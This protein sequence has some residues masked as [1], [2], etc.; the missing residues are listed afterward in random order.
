MTKTPSPPG[1][2]N[3]AGWWWWC[4]W[5][6]SRGSRCWLFRGWGWDGRM[7]RPRAGQT[8][9]SPPSGAVG[10]VVPR[11]TSGLLGRGTE[12]LFSPPSSPATCPADRKGSAQSAEGSARKPEPVRR[13]GLRGRRELEAAFWAPGGGG[14]LES[15]NLAPGRS[16]GRPLLVCSGRES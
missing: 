9:L 5:R 12:Q 1:G 3:R 13:P 14:R 8:G 6:P 15:W 16:K 10:P 7:P 4:C 2:R 11:S